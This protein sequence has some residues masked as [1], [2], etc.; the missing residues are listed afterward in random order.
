[1]ENL[2]GDKALL[3]EVIVL[4]RENDTPRL[5]EELSQGVQ[6]G[7]A[8]A[9]SKTAHALKGMVGA[10]NAT[11]AWAAAKKLEM[12]ARAGMTAALRDEAGHFVQKLRALLVSLE[13]FAGADHR[14]IKWM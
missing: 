5:L 7:N 12:T 9:V 11:D 6:T 8:D 3:R 2:G 10:F 4:C 13:T 14:D 1:M